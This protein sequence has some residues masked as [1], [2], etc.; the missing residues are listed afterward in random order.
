MLLLLL[1]GRTDGQRLAAYYDGCSISLHPANVSDDDHR[2]HQNHPVPG[3]NSIRCL[4]L[5]A[6]GIDNNN[7]RD[8][9]EEFRGSAH[10]YIKEKRKSRAFQERGDRRAVPVYAVRGRRGR[11]QTKKYGPAV[12]EKRR[13]FAG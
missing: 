5:E 9:D 10:F 6:F 3:E 8:D 12:K 7:K 13:K 11:K 4:R 2:R 1:D